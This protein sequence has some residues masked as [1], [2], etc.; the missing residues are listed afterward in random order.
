MAVTIVISIIAFN[1]KE[2][3]YKLSF[4]PYS[5][6]E[7]KEW[8]RF[9]SYSLVHADFIH[10]ALNMWVMYIFANNTMIAFTYF[11]GLKGVWYFILL[12]V[13]GTAFAVIKD[14]V[15]NKTNPLYNGI[16]ASGAVSAIVFSSIIIFPTEKLMIFPLP[17]PLPAYILGVLYLA[18]SYFMAQKGKD[19]IGHQAHFWGALYGV[20]FTIAIRPAFIVELFSKIGLSL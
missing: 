10:L 6:D 11:F 14:Y 12:Y 4:N 19:N 8:Y 15:D 20:A 5:V 17:I 3:F 16:G 2:L 1:N 13:G 7:R 18:Y 9:L